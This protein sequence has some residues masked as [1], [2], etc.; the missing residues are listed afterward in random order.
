MWK[1]TGLMLLHLYF[2]EQNGFL[3]EVASICLIFGL[4]FW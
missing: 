2:V 4:M 3:L 1:E